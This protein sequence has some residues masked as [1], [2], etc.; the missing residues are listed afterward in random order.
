[1][2]RIILFLSSISLIVLL[3]SFI[4]QNSNP[5]KI[6]ASL[7]G[8]DE[9]TV[10]ELVLGGT[11]SKENTVATSELKMGKVVFS[12]TVESPRCFYLKIKNADPI[13]EVMIDSGDQIS[14][15]AN[16]SKKNAEDGIV[17]DFEDIKISGSKTQEEYKVKIEPREELNRQ[18]DAMHQKYAGIYQKLSMAS[19]E[20]N[21]AATDSLMQTEEYKSLSREESDFFK[22]VETSAEKMITEN[23][24]SW[25]GPFLML[26]QYSYFTKDLRPLYDTFSEAAKESFYGKR[27]FEELYPVSLAGS[28]IPDF[29]LTDRDGTTKPS[30]DVIKGNKYVL[31]DFWASWCAPCRKEIPNLK[32]LYAKYHDKGLQIISISTD[33]KAAD[34]E[35]ALAAEK[36]PWINYRDVDESVAAIFKV[37]SIPAIFLVDGNG[38]LVDDGLRGESLASKL[39]ELFK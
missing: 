6:E 36:L 17:Y 14:I 38:I 12:S 8:L 11:H 32:V 34:W 35:K 26:Y 31:I 20:K 24:D 1:M 18:F 7:S 16:V 10:I 28:K 13:I 25:W 9:G 30:M 21:K 29:T 2:K 33:R 27:V 4:G 23:K 22:R 37:N 15:S 19:G 5:F 3:S 39:E